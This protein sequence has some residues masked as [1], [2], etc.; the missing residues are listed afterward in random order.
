MD[1]NN[2]L[3]DLTSVDPNND[4]VKYSMRGVNPEKKKFALRYLNK[5][6][7]GGDI[8]NLDQAITISG[9]SPAEMNDML[10]QVASSDGF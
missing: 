8:K 1:T 7:Q 5:Y 3:D 4:L 6:L 2:T 10:G 9:M